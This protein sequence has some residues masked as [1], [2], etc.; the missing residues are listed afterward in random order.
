LDTIANIQEIV[1]EKEWHFLLLC[2][3]WNIDVNPLEEDSV[4]EKTY[5]QKVKRVKYLRRCANKW[6]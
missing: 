6:D 2:G 1:P 5:K 3:D 4:N